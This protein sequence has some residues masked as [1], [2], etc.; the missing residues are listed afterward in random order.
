VP[1]GHG[2]LGS[3]LVALAS[4]MDGVALVSGPGSAELDITDAQVVR[5]RVASFVDSSRGLRPV[6]VNAA[7]YTSVDAAEA[8]SERAYEVN[9]I[10]PGLLAA[11]CAEFA[12]P[13]VQVSTDYVFAGS[14][15]RPYEAHDP[16]GPRSAYGRGK[17][18][19][20][21]AVLSSTARAYVVR[22][23]WLYGARGGNFVKTMIGLERSQPTV[24]VVDD[25][26]GSPTWCFD[27]ARALL[28]LAA[29]TGRV[30]PGVLHCTNGGSTT[31]YGF[32][33]AIFEELG[34][35]PERVLPCTSADYPRPAPR[36]AY[37]VLS[38]A[39]WTAAGLSPLRSWR[40]ALAAAFISAR[41]SFRGT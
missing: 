3:E 19:G 21:R 35:D 6:V 28:E 29:A 14:A 17:L 40:D 5:D 11:A 34:A 26:H 9:G 16:V 20:E 12:V 8:D 23:A 1:G 37:S 13:L 25:Q 18:A 10:A 31:W 32:A 24:S 30:P 15:T 4:T 22:T 41:K 39:S 36:P 7:A 2:Q 27:L 33:R 38:N